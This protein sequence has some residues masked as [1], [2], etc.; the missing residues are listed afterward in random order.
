[1]ATGKITIKREE[2]DAYAELLKRKAELAAQAAVIKE[3]IE[4]FEAKVLEQMDAAGKSS[5]TRFGWTLAIARGNG[6]VAWKKEFIRVAG[7]EAATTLA[8]SVQGTGK[9]EIKITAPSEPNE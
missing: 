1:M 5:A 6:S 8:L 2:F 7:E 3:S 9:Q 4:Q